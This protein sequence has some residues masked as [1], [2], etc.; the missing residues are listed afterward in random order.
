M[1]DYNKRL[2]HYPYMKSFDS[3]TCPNC[4]TY[5][6][7]LPVD[8]DEDGLF[9]ALEVKPC[10]TCGA[11]LCPCCSVFK[12][13]GCDGLHC[14]E[15]IVLVEDGTPNPLKCCAVC[16][17][18]CEPLPAKIEPQRAP[19]AFPQ[20]ACAWCELA[21]AAG[22]STFQ[23]LGEVLHTACANERDDYARQMAEEF[24]DG[25]CSPYRSSLDHVSR[26]APQ[27][28]RAIADTAVVEQFENGKWV[29]RHLVRDGDVYAYRA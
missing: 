29:E 5:F 9:V 25:Q 17:A 18:E 6:D 21:I 23:Q 27:M 20:V 15:H 19:A 26:I 8:G 13:E 3:A 4:K 16:A 11:L 12:C 10:A 14:S 1:L 24:D 7:R 28:E 22:Q 2:W